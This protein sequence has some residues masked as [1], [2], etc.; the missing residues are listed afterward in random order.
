MDEESGTGEIVTGGAL[1]ILGALEASSGFGFCPLC[2]IA[3]P[4]L[5]GVGLLKRIKRRMK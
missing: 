1:G 2:F 3:V 5:L 4:I